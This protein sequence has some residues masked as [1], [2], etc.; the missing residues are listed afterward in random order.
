MR[1]FDHILNELIDSEFIPV[2]LNLMEDGEE[3]LNMIKNFDLDYN[4]IE[5]VVF[6]EVKVNFLEEV[7]EAGEEE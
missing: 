5:D 4:Q 2:E 6:E 1:Y 7:E 3:V